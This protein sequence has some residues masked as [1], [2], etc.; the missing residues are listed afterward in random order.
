MGKKIDLKTKELEARRLREFID[1]SGAG[2]DAAFAR[3][4]GVPGGK[5]MLSQHLQCLRPISLECAVAYAIGSNKP[6]ELISERLAKIIDSLPKPVAVPTNQLSE[7]PAAVYKLPQKENGVVGE[8]ID[9]ARQLDDRGK[10]ILLQ[11][12][13]A[14]ASEMSAAPQREPKSST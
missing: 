4:C 9:I 10:N 7:P 5:S 13:R 11:T 12:A 14:V 1:A 3:K 8:I 6:L 2:S